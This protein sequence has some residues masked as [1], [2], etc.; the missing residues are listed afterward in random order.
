M[1]IIQIMQGTTDLFGLDEDG[2]L[3]KWSKRCVGEDFKGN[4]EYIYGWAFVQDQFR[5]LKV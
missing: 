4:P 3:Y 5:P 1:K 2:M